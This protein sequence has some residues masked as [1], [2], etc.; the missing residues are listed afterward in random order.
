MRLKCRLGIF[1]LHL[2]RC[3]WEEIKDIDQPH[4]AAD[5]DKQKRPSHDGSYDRDAE[6]H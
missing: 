3:L 4:L 2:L 1:V 6:G 5:A